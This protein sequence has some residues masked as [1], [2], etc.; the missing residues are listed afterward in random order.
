MRKE[1]RKNVAKLIRL[2]LKLHDH[3]QHPIYLNPFEQAFIAL[4]LT[5]VD[6]IAYK[7]NISKDSSAHLMR[8]VYKKL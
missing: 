7:L 4:D 5:S 3:Y 1:E 6:D 2:V 8:S